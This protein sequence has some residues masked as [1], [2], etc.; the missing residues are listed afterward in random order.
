MPPDVAMACFRCGP[1]HAI[2]AR[3]HP[4]FCGSGTATCAHLGEAERACGVPRTGAGGGGETEGGKGLSLTMVHAEVG[5]DMC[6][7]RGGRRELRMGKG[8]NGSLPRHEWVM[9]LYRGWS[10]IGE[11]RGLSATVLVGKRR[12]LACAVLGGGGGGAAKRT[13]P[14]RSWRGMKGWRSACPRQGEDSP[15]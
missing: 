11:E 10:S 4:P 14:C 6:S 3:E 9:V 8:R 12:G 15:I 5:V 2:E 1:I 13:Y 7:P